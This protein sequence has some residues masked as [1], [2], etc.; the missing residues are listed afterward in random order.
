VERVTKRYDG[1]LLRPKPIAGPFARK[2]ERAFVRLS[3]GVTEEN[4]VGEAGL[5]QLLRQS[6]VGGRVIQVGHVPELAGLRRQRGD[7]AGIRVAERVDRD[8]RHA[9]EVS[10]AIRVVDPA[11]LA[12]IQHEWRAGVGAEEVVLFKRDSILGCTRNH[13]MLR[14]KQNVGQAP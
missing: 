10:V 12:V 5:A 6:G 8:A 13:V 7:Q 9:V 4:P 2:L 3:P 11:S 1:V 14:S